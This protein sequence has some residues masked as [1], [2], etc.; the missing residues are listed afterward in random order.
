MMLRGLPSVLQAA[1][2]DGLVFDPFSL[3]QDCLAAS[4]VDVGRG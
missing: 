4:E 3:Q 2:C 1:L